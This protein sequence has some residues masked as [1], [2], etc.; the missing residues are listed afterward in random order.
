[1][2]AAL[3]IDFTDKELKE[4][5]SLLRTV[6]GAIAVL[7]SSLSAPSLE[8]LLDVG[9]NKVS[10]ILRDLHSIIDVPSN[11]LKPIRAHH[12]SVRDY[13]LDERRCTE[14]HFQIDEQKAQAQL[15]RCCLRVLNDSLHKDLCDLHMPDARTLDVDVD[16]KARCLPPHLRYACRYWVPHVRHSHDIDKFTDPILSFIRT[17]FLHW[18]ETLSLLNMLGVII[19]LI[20]DL[21]IVFVCHFPYNSPSI[22]IAIC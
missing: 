5:A 22:T 18:L 14:S 2:C 1:L 15:A 20:G 3:R 11:N 4:V 12:I 19:E 7:F 16:V 21:E 10:N 17:H 8:L 13:L 9:Q 6:L